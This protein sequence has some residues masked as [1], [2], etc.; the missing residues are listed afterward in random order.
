MIFYAL[1]TRRENITVAGSHSDGTK[2]F[3]TAGTENTEEAQRKQIHSLCAPS[4]L[5]VPLW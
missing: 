1:D 3:T 5:S 2:R 4:V